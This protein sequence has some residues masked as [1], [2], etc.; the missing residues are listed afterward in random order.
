MV[1]GCYMLHLELAA[2]VFGTA[3]THGLQAEDVDL[4]EIVG[5]Q[6]LKP[7][8]VLSPLHFARFHQ[9]PSFSDLGDSYCNTTDMAYSD[10]SSDDIQWQGYLA[11]NII[12]FNLLAVLTQNQIPLR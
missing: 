4:E 8:Q 12:Q 9:S 10:Y 5:R 7:V 1:L 2:G 3:H 6:L 11:I